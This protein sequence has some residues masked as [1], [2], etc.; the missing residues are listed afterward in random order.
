MEYLI[1]FL[2]GV[3][4]FISPCM[5]PLL[6]AYVSYFALGME[7]RRHTAARAA[8]FVAGFALVFCLL[9]LTAGTLGAALSRHRRA[10]DLVCGAFVIL[11]GLAY[12]DV[13][14]LPFF[15][16]VQRAGTEGLWGAFLFGM[17]YAV[18]LTPCVGAFL[19]SALML[20]ASVGGAWKGFALLLAYSL[21]LGIPFVL[22]AVLIDRLGGAFSW[23]KAHYR[24]LNMICGIFLILM[25]AAM[26]TGLLN[27][28]LGAAA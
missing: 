8:M 25:G 6:P 13:I 22:S 15:K 14:P 5:L 18:G 28:L 16:G 26:A 9:G 19:G 20:A 11:F 23:V 21:G 10:V 24:A 27:R 12:L 17:I 2:E 3:V 4:S 1:T 7:R